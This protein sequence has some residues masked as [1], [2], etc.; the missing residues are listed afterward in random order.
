MQL[1]ELL[2]LYTI[3]F[4]FYIKITNIIYRPR[5]DLYIP[6]CIVLL[7]LT[8]LTVPGVPTGVLLG[9]QKT[10]YVRFFNFAVAPSLY[11]IIIYSSSDGSRLYAS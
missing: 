11:V 10:N 2:M 3:T 1:H 5:P 6:I 7:Y 4:L 8:R 9:L